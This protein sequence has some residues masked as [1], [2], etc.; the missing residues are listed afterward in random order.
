MI[1]N[2]QGASEYGGGVEDH[3]VHVL[4]REMSFTAQ[5]SGYLHLYA[6]DAWVM[7][8]NNAGTLRVEIARRP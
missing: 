4:G 8:R 3:E 6:N 7:Y 2:G 1:A 5:E